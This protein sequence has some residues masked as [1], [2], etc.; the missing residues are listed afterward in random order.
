MQTLPTDLLLLLIK[1][2]QLN[3]FNNSWHNATYGT[4]KVEQSEQLDIKQ[5]IK[6]AV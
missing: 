6:I 2:I 5:Q 1:S 4:N 3:N